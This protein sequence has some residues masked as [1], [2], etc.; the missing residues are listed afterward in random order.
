[1]AVYGGVG[2]QPQIDAMR[3]TDI[4]VGTPGRIL[5]HLERRTIDLSHVQFLVID[6]AD[7]M[8]EMGFIEDVERIIGF[9]PQER[10]TMLFSATMAQSVHALI[11]R[12][13]KDPVMIKEKIHVDRSLLRQVYYDVGPQDKFS[14]LVH[15]IKNKTE[16]LA[17]VFCATRHEVDIVARNLKMQGIH[18]MAVHGGL[19]QNK[20]SHAV[21]SLKREDIQVLVATDVAARGLDIQ[22]ISHIY[23]YDVPKTSEEYVHRIGRTARAG[24]KGDA[25]T[26]LVHRDHDNFG[27]VMSDRTLQIQK[28]EPPQFERVKFIR[29]GRDDDREDGRRGGQR[30][31]GSRRSGGFGGQREGGFRGSR[32]DGEG[33]RDSDRPHSSGGRRPYRSGSQRSQGPRFGTIR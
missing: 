29:G 11:R 28:E 32:G 5:D 22:N 25:V 10:Q 9:I 1:M 16:G 33:R 19:S 14:L 13:L 2:I 7:K 21:N 27:R 24:N 26:L 15:L 3:N 6:E 8:F 30:F 23:N 18:S 4:V 17:I 20:R 31:G 12:H